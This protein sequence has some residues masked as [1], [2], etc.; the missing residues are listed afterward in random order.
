MKFFMEKIEPPPPIRLTDKE[1][2]KL[3]MSED[4]LW[5]KNFIEHLG[6]VVRELKRK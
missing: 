6:G 4:D 1:R 2:S 3:E 5:V